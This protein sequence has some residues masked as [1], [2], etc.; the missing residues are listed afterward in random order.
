LDLKLE[1]NGKVSSINPEKY[2]AGFVI[3]RPLLIIPESGK[4]S[5]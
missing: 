4:S 2:G 3:I 5:K 1:A